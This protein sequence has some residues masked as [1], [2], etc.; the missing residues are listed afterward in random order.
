MTTPIPKYKVKS[1]T[2]MDKENNTNEVVA[3]GLAWRTDILD[4][5]CETIQRRSHRAKR[6]TGG[7]R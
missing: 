3:C 1:Y 7:P 6:W 4:T 5:F 2:G